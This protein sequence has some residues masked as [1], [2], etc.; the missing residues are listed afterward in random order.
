MQF[1]V[2][3]EEHRREQ[4]H[5]DAARGAARGERKVEASQAVGFR[6]QAIDFAVAD[7]APH[8]ERAEVDRTFDGHVGEVHRL[9]ELPE[10]RA[11]QGRQRRPPEPAAIPA[12]AVETDDEGHQVK[13]QRQ[14]PKERHHGDILAQLVGDREQQHDAAGREREPKQAVRPRGGRRR[15]GVGG[16]RGGRRVATQP[17]GASA[18]RGQQS[19]GDEPGGP[20]ERLRLA[21]QVR[22]DGERVGEER[23]QRADVGQ[24]VE[25]V[26]R[27]AWVAAAE[28]GLEQRAGGRQH[29]VGQAD[30]GEEQPKDVAGR[31]RVADG[32]PV[33]AGRDGQETDREDEQGEVQEHLLARTEPSDAAVGVG[34]AREEHH[35]EEQHARRPHGRSAAEPRQDE[36]RDE[37]LDEEEQERAP[38]DG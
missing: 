29:E 28:P 35:L 18:Q 26:G 2:V 37:R 38:E 24:G 22:F 6:A 7:H 17:D 8:E 1:E 33:F 15:R 30:A 19:I 31:L 11:E 32:F 34:V 16:R 14:H 25:A 9:M 36:A 23:E 21:G 5:E 27:D 12:G 4:G 3:R 20:H 10:H 13:P